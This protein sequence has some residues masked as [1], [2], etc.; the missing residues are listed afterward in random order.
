[1]NFDRYSI[2][3]Q[4]RMTNERKHVDFFFFPIVEQVEKVDRS[5]ILT[6]ENLIGTHFSVEIGKQRERSRWKSTVLLMFFTEILVRWFFV[7][8]FINDL[9]EISS[10]LSLSLSFS[11][12]SMKKN[13]FL[14]RDFFVTTDEIILL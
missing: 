9:M 12:L 13:H 10:P 4:Y 3:E 6:D 7:V 8:S 5:F 11:R 2:V 14:I 1:M